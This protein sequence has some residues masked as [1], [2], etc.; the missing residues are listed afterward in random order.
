MPNY[1]D[2]KNNASSILA[3]GITNVTTSLTVTSGD[4]AKFPAA[5]FRITIDNEIMTCSTRSADTLT[6]VRAAE[7]TTA[8]AHNAGAA[9]RLNITAGVINELQNRPCLRV[10]SLAAQALPSQAFTKVVLETVRTDTHSGWSIAN[11]Q[12]TIPETGFYLISGSCSL[13]GYGDG[14]RFCLSMF[15]NVAERARLADV[16]VGG[17]GNVVIAGVGGFPLTAG[18]IIYN[19][20]YYSLTGP[21]STIGS[22][23]TGSLSIARLS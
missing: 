1:L 22:E 19:C 4:G 8:A 20:A 9:V 13:A 5:N 12:Y 23:A 10:V 17:T 7:G 18:D 21:Y 14:G 15:V 3:A 11:N 6:V 16:Y 2:I